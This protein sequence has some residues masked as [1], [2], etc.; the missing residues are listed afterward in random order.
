MFGPNGLYFMQRTIQT[1]AACILLNPF[2]V[3]GRGLRFEKEK[4]TFFVSNSEVQVIGEY[5]FRNPSPDSC[6]VAMRYPFVVLPAQPFPAFIRVTEASDGRSVA[7][8]T[9]RDGVRFQLD[10]DPFGLRVIRVEY[11]QPVLSKRFE[12]LL[13]TTASW[14]EGLKLAEF[15]ILLPPGHELKSCSLPYKK[16]R[17]KDDGAAYLIRQEDFLPKENLVFQW[18]ARHDR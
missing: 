9:D 2:S 12:Y 5:Y 6:R 8:R 17:H 14:G 1:A 13:T 11:R 15:R 7:Y 18:E 16:I 4:I 10:A 3:L